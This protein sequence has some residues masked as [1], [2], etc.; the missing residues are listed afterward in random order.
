M[1]NYFKLTDDMVFA[2]ADNPAPDNMG[3]A[4][5]RQ[6]IQDQIDSL[7]AQ[8]SQQDADL[9][10]KIAVLQPAIDVLAAATS[11]D[12]SGDISKAIAAKPPAPLP[13]PVQPAPD[14]DPA[15]EQKVAA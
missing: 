6:Y 4:Y 10:A 12:I 1:P 9:D 7:N 14:P 2:L 3:T 13:D 15:I 5:H 8:K 11:T